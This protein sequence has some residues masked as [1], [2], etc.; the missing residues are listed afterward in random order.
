MP[1]FFVSDLI[2][3][4][5]A[6]GL[7]VPII[8]LPGYGLGWWLQVL[9]FRSLPA[10]ER[11]SMALVFGLS[12][13]PI[14]LYLPFRLGSDRWMWAVLIYLAMAGVVPLLRHD[15]RPKWNEIPRAALVVAAA[16]L[17]LSVFLSLDIT[18]GKKL[19]PSS[20]IIDTNARSQDIASLSQAKSLPP[21]SFFSFPGKPVPLHYHY[22]YF[23][24]ASVAVRCA[25][26]LVSARMA[27][28]ATVIVT[29]FAFLTVLPLVLKW[30]HPEGSPRLKVIGWALLLIGGLDILPVGAEMIRRWWIGH[31][32]M[33]PAPDIEWWNGRAQVFSWVDTA[34]WHP[35]HIGA[36]VACLVAGLILYENTR[37]SG[38]LHWQYVLAAGIALAGGAAASVL[39]AGV[40]AGFL[41]I[42]AIELVLNAPRLSVLVIAS[43]GVA[44]LLILSFLRE[45]APITQTSSDLSFAIALRPF[46]PIN[47]AFDYLAIRSPWVWNLAYLLALPVNYFLELGVFFIASLWWLRERHL[48]G[49]RDKLKE[50]LLIGLLSISMLLVT[51]IQSG[52]VAANDFGYRGILPAQLV[53]LLFASELFDCYWERRPREPGELR[54]YQAALVTLCIGS[55]TTLCGIFIMRDSIGFSNP[56]VD[57]YH[58]TLRT[59]GSAARL[60]DLRQAYTWI[61][62]NTPQGAIVQED[63]LS[64]QTLAAQY[65]ERRT[66]VY[67][68]FYGDQI[69]TNTHSPSSLFNATL[70]LFQGDVTPADKNAIC[71]AQGINY[72]VVQDSDSIWYN[73]K[74]YVWTEKPLFS[75]ARARVFPCVTGH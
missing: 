69:L 74:S 33:I 34:I 68:W 38:A 26:S 67:S 28:V 31:T 24:P 42:V 71:G 61:R 9:G 4:L 3:L 62:F 39:V 32:S 47:I 29:G 72:I 27:L 73:H 23:L 10:H 2:G 58:V 60:Y 65:G 1:H 44:L 7:F 13:V 48:R 11:W 63:P 64:W 59:P 6:L 53:L 50:H 22:A 45:S 66:V 55:V 75:S 36:M 43:G 19:Y 21:E 25:R 49:Y 41:V 51:L 17:L 35:H 30:A 8:L 52:T 5:A 46:Q 16:W 15:A 56:G 14:L 18:A 40:F 20:A 54:L 57:M 12:M 70:S 37:N